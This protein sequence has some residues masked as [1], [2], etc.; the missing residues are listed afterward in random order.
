MTHLYT[1]GGNWNDSES[2]QTLG[3]SNQYI[4]TLTTGNA[5][6]AVILST[7]VNNSDNDGILDA[8]KA[9]QGYTDVKT[10]TWVPLPGATRGEKDLF[11]QFDYMCSALNAD[12]TCDFTQPNLYPSPDAQGNDPLAMVTQAFANYGVHLHLKPGNAIQESTCTDSATQFCEFPNQPGVVAW[13]GSVELSKVWPVNYSGCTSNPT[14]ATC[15]PRFPYGQKDSYHYVLFGYSLAIPAW[16]TRAGSITSIT[17]TGGASGGTGTGTVVTTGL[18]TTCPT[19]ITISGVQGNPNLNAI[20][21]GVSCDSGLTTINFSTSSTVPTWTY[22]NN[23]LPEPVIAVTSGKVTSISGYSDLGGSDSV[24]SLGQWESSPT[25]DMSKSAT[26][27]AGTL[28]HEIGHTLGLSHGGLYFDTPG[29]YI[30][31]FE[32]NCKPNYQSSMNYLFQLDGVGPNAAV[33]YSNQVLYGEIP[34]A[35][36]TITILGG[37]SSTT[38]PNFTTIPFGSVVNLTDNLGKPA[39]FTTSAWYSN[40]PPSSTASAAT[41]HCDGSPLNN[42]TAYRV[43]G[44]VDAISPAWSTGQNITFDGSQYTDLRGYSDQAN[45]D[46]RQVGATSGDFASLASET[47]YGNAGV[48]FAG[49]GGVTFAGSGGVTFAGSGGVTFAGSGGVLFAGSGGVL[50]A[51]SGGVT[52]AGSGGVTYAGSGGVTFAGSG[53]VTFAGSGGVTFAGSGGVTFAGSGG[54]STNELDY[55][56][57]NSF[58]RPPNSP[59]ITP[60]MTSGAETSVIVDWTAPAFGVVQYYTVYRGCNTNGSDAVDIGVVNGVGGAAPATEFIDSNPV[61]CSGSSGVVYT[62]ATTL[63]PVQID[64]TQRSSAPSVPAIVKNLQTI[65][66]GTLQSSV[67]YSTPPPT[68]SVTATAETNGSPNGLQVN[69]VATGPCSVG[70]QTVASIASGGASTA[71]VTVNDPGSNP[72]TC[73]VVASQS[74]TNPTASSMPPYYDAANSVSESFTIEPQG[75]TTQPQTITF[76]AL[77][78][79]Q[80]GSTFS[81]SASSNSGLGVTF[82]AVGP[83]QVGTSTG[84]ATVTTTGVGRCTITASAPAGTVSSNS[85]SPASVPQPFTITPAVLKVTANNITAPYGT[86]PTLAYNVTGFEPGDSAASVLG[87]T[88]PALSTTANQGSSP[89]TYPITISTGSLAAANYSF[90]FV[91]GTLTISP[92]PEL[93]V[94]PSAISF[95]SVTL[96]SITTQNITVS[97]IGTAPA[98]ISQPLISIV[99]GGN[100]NEFVAVNLC[101]TPLAAGKSC[102]ITIAFVAGPFYAQQSAILEIM[103]NAPNSPQPVKLT[104]TV[105]QSQTITLTGVPASA[106]Y[107]NSFTVSATASSGLPVTFTASG[108]C[109]V[110][111]GTATYTMNSGSGTCSV[112]A[113]QAGNLSYAAATQVT[114]NVSANPASQTITLGSLPASAAYKSSFTAAAT[115]SS[116]LTVT[117]TA[118][119][120]CTVAPGTATYT[121]TSGT[122]TCSVITNQAGNSNYSAAAQVTKTVSATPASQT[123]SFTTGPPAAAGYRTSFA[124]TATASSTLA[125]NYTSSGAC[126]NSGATY[127]MTASSGTCSVIANQAGNSNYSAAPTITLPVTATQAPQAITFSNNPPATAPYNSTFKVAATGGASGNAVTFSSSGSCSNSG[128]TYTMTSGTG[129]CSVI[130][131]QAGNS[132]YAAATSVTKTVSASLVAQTITFTSNPPASANLNSSFTVA[133]TGGGSGI[134]IVFTS[135]GACTNSGAK[136]TITSS[137]GTCSVIANQAGNSNYAPAAQVT[138]TVTA[139]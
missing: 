97:N 40:T 83:C 91:N 68:V 45:L 109:S 108:A 44:P 12:N 89:G 78:N 55:V 122:G 59:T 24:V 21:D 104:A 115:A 71:T 74:G 124:V 118:S 60:V 48:T 26:V 28:F 30:P 73:T 88:T 133:A 34:G 139:K 135:S 95:G 46:L 81:V 116:G 17:T 4:D 82:G 15:A 54:A 130:A 6:A 22:P 43:D 72:A 2:P 107:K 1:S 113:N 134:A 85:Y 32:A 76:S 94:A 23:T 105:L 65:V 69:F 101:P 114:K 132:N 131:N 7:P 64:P 110:A 47:S 63:N 19:R 138:K 3:Q 79:V 56:T 93:T 50:F 129:T 98:T 58:V 61:T 53:G 49:S 75:S 27:V 102:T 51:G 13:N 66:L 70:G 62:I 11:V 106:A 96:G 52:F 80:Y 84:T 35:S 57:A 38:N 121:M 87:S 33:T 14:Q 39:S 137:T 8:W 103:D 5:Y 136:Y 99:Q 120:A 117:F 125:V 128:T 36:P 77:P 31:T 41:R 127:T 126:S 37:D 123:I 9:A 29:S 112:I 42:D 18:G 20:Y 86:I 92:A 67:T 119:G 100:S 25:Q 90:Y 16:T 10:S 111:P